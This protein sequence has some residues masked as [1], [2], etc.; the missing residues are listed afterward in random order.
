MKPHVSVVVPAFRNV[1]HLAETLDSILNQTYQDYEVV[2]ADH[3]SG[4]GSTALLAR[5]ADHPKVRILSP[6]PAGGGAVTNWNRVSTE[7]R[8]TLL[9]LV[10]ADDLISRD[11]LETQVAVLDANPS[12]VLVACQRKVIDSKGRCM[13]K[14]R[15]LG[16]LQGFVGGRQAIRASVRAGTNLFGEP[17]CVL[18]RRDVL[19][20]V[21]WWESAFPYLIDQATYS[22][23]MLHGDAYAIRGAYASFR[24]S[25]QQWSVRLARTQ[26]IQAQAFH[27]WMREQEPDLISEWDISVGGA[28][29]TLMAN[30]RRAAYYFLKSRM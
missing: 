17:G 29:A 24:I 2:V 21:G 20:R 15:G 5:Y 14:A 16:P 19:E 1:Q 28:K 23:V 26:A 3:S 13:L 22:K 6:T 10:C 7:A 27:R 18:M 12:V 9:K 8:G 30:A 11:A 4:D 25:N